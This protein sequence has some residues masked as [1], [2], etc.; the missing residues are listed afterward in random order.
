VKRIAET[1]EVARSNL[2][3]RATGS[4]AKRGPQTRAGDAELRPI[5]DAWS[6]AGRPTGTG[7]SPRS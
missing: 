5:F 4:R 2:V 3:E 6:M 7:G 1:L